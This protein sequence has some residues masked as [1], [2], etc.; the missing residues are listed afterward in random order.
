MHLCGIRIMSNINQWQCFMVK[1]IFLEIKKKKEKEKKILLNKT[2][3]TNFCIGNNFAMLLI[4]ISEF[5]R[6]LES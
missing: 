1:G 4:F 3:N 6:N 2:N 5:L